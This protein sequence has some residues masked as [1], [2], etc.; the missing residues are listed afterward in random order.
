MYLCFGPTPSVQLL[1][2]SIK[3]LLVITMWSRNVLIL[4]FLYC[5]LSFSIYF[6]FFSFLLFLSMLLLVSFNIVMWHKT[7][8]VCILSTDTCRQSPAGIYRYHPYEKCSSFF[9][10]SLFIQ[11]LIYN[12]YK[13]L[14]TITIE[15]K[16][17]LSS[18]YLSL[19]FEHTHTHVHLMRWWKICHGWSFGWYSMFYSRRIL[20]NDEKQHCIKVF[21]C[22]CVYMKWFQFTNNFTMSFSFS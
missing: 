11:C 1:R 14:N 19:S 17:G 13:T 15:G 9:Y 12:I 22:V 3:Y 2:Y 5:Y 6:C 18:L 7:K 20:D 8:I 10:L 21:I 16:G 4:F